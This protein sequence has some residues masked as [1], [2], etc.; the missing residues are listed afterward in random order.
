MR[1]HSKSEVTEKNPG[2]GIILEINTSVWELGDT[3]KNVGHQARIDD[4]TRYVLSKKKRTLVMGGRGEEK[5][6]NGRGE[7]KGVKHMSK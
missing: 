3:N 5:R 6:N 7:E 2:S 1:G 4:C